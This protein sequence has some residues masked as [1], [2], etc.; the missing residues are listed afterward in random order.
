MGR[1][2]KHRPISKEALAALVRSGYSLREIAERF[3][4]SP[5][6]VGREAKR[7]GI[8]APVKARAADVETRIVDC[9]NEHGPDI[10]LREI[11]ERLAVPISTVHRHRIAI[12]LD[13]M[14]LRR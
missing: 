8:A 14:R 13:V 9:I 6:T 11:S 2:K 3:R 7:Q 4:Q 1:P 5:Q 12:D 10:K